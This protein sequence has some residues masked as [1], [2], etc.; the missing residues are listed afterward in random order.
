MA[1][2]LPRAAAVLSAAVAAVLAT[3]APAP[4]ATATPP[5][6]VDFELVNTS[7]D[8]RSRVDKLADQLPK[9]DVPSILANANRQG[10]TGDACTSPALDAMQ[11]APLRKFCF[12]AE[13]T[14]KVGGTVEWMPQG[15]TTVA[16]ANDDQQVGGKQ[17]LLVSWYDKGTDPIKG[18]RVSFLDPA[19]SK[20]RH[21]LLVYPYINSNGNPSYE[22]VTTPQA[23]NGNSVHAGGTAW[24]GNY[25]YVVDTARGI[26]I[27]D[28]RTIFDLGAADNGDTSN[29]ALVGR[30]D[31][32]YHGFGYRYVM[33]QVAGWSNPEGVVDHPGDYKCTATGR[34]RYSYV[35]LDRSTSP[36]TLLTGEYCADQHNANLNG[37]V[38]RWNLATTGLPA[39]D[40]DGTWRATSAYRL[41]KPRVQGVTA[42]AGRWYLSTSNGQNNAGNFQAAVPDKDTGA[43]VLTTDGPN[44]AV[45]IGVEDLS[46]WPGN[47]EVWTVTEHPG[48][49]VLYS[50]AR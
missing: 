4:A 18:V 1:V 12:N 44:R 40:S 15:V 14:G 29:K 20:Y 2:R 23:G 11:E 8:L 28:M 13:D 27:F 38:A 49:R 43:G 30:H 45:A 50:V 32:M 22:A 26:R 42:A 41:P 6:L 37:R 5:N 21:V 33:P 16:D 48:K 31:N 19:T 39:P 7:G 17:A 10:S 46:Y 35:S 24:Y 25:L 36:H 47:N 34:Q 9:A 3:T